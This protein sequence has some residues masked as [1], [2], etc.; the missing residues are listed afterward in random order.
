MKSESAT[1]NPLLGQR[2]FVLVKILSRLQE[3]EILTNLVLVMIESG[4]LRDPVAFQKQ[5]S[6]D[7]GRYVSQNKVALDSATWQY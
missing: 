1:R 6:M 3:H 2:E 7:A 5:G 4:S